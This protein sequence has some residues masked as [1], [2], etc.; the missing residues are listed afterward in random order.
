MRDRILMPNRLSK[1]FSFPSVLEWTLRRPLVILACFTAMTV[2]FAL[3][4]PKLSFRTSIYDLLIENL[5]ESIHY[6]NARKVFGSD[7]II[8]VVVKAEDIFDHTTFKKIEALSDT[9]GRIEGVRRVISLPEIK[10]KVDLAGEWTT[11]ELAKVAAPVELFKKNLFSADHKVAAITLVLENETVHASVVRKINDIIRHESRDLFLYQIG[12]PSVSQ[13]LVRYTIKDFQILPVLTLAL[14]TLVLVILFRNP[15]RVFIPLMVVLVVLTWT[16]GLMALLQIPLSLLTMIVP[17]FLIAVGTAYSLHVLSEYIS[18]AQQVASNK[19]VAFSTLTNAALPCTLADFTTLFGVGSLFVNRIRAIHEFALFSCFGMAS[20]LLALLFLLP[21]VL[22]FIPL[23]SK[24][25]EGYSGIGKILDRFLDLIVHLNLNHQKTSLTIIGFS[26]LAAVLGI[27]F[28]QV[29]TNPIEY[30]KAETPL[31]RNFHDI[32]RQLSGSFPIQVIIESP[33][34]YFFEDPKHIAD[35]KHFQEFLETLPYVDK[36]VSFADYV[37]LV[38]YALNQYDSKYYTIPREAFETR[39]AINNYQGLLGEDMFLRFMTPQ[40]NKAGILLL[41]HMSSSKDF[42]KIRENILTYARQ[43][44]SAHLYFEVTGFGVAI[45]ASSHLLTAGQIKSISLSMALIFGIMFLMFLSA[46]VGL[47]ALLPNFF[48]IIINFGMMGWLGIPLSMSTSLIASIAIGLAV[49]DTIH[50]LYRYNIEFK[51]DLDKNR[52]LRD[53]I[54]H[55]GK[56][57]IFT[58]LTISMGFSVLIF[59]HFEPTA[60]FGFLMVTTLLSALIGDL[61]LLPTLM[62]H[63]EL[64]TAWDLLKLIPNLGGLSAGLAHELIQPLTAIKMGSDFLLNGISKKRKL[65]ELHLFDI[66]NEIGRQTDRASEIVHRVRT[67]GEPPGFTRA[68]VNINEP[69]M[70]V[71]SIIRYQLSLDNIELKLELD[72]K[73]LPVLAHKNK[74]GQVVYNL[75]TNAHEAINEKKKTAGGAGQPMIRIRSFSEG[76]RV[77]LSVSDTGI[78][79]SADHRR[80][81]YEPF[82]TTKTSG[83]GKGLG[84][85]ISNEIVRDFGGRIEVESDQNKGTTFKVSFPRI[86]P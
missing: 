2:F 20:L 18:C 67:F 8:R 32:H 57:I 22:V 7:E 65:N 1:P 44:F 46:K 52:A 79:I 51:R 71:I 74:L 41:T 69:I 84:L 66:I 24:R 11:D 78:G 55:V 5:P 42:L 77:V 23:S 3:Q 28:I 59:S 54:R 26:V 53:T 68:R 62:L 12:M 43:N 15:A 83:Q 61:V 76:D 81:I 45:S 19:E 70:D 31:R 17:V 82:Y 64:V 33:Q 73:P 85:S 86:R 63:V 38:N 75:L 30:F 13:A 37:M 29:E 40:L 72:Q 56:P 10:K 47:I 49:D 25:I 27:F 16:F 6:A 50:Y 21:A 80:R 48:P 9:L 39:M 58:T 36:T 35:L 34:D 14:I 4:L 60:I